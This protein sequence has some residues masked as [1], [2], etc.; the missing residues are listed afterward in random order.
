MYKLCVPNGA[1]CMLYTLSCASEVCWDAGA[2][3]RDSLRAAADRLGAH[4]A[5]IGRAHTRSLAFSH[6]FERKASLSSPDLM[7]PSIPLLGSFSVAILVFLGHDRVGGAELGPFRS[8]HHVNTVKYS[9][10]AQHRGRLQRLTPAHP[11]SVRPTTK[12]SSLPS[13]RLREVEIPSVPLP[14]LSH[15]SCSWYMT[16]VMSSVLTRPP[17]L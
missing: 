17:G 15:P 2:P 4:R 9:H 1:Q 8:S 11:R 16:A 5:A 13:S 14:M 3:K 7:A 6:A 10:S 12:L